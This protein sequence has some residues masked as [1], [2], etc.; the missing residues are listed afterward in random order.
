MPTYVK[1]IGW[2]IFALALIDFIRFAAS[3]VKMRRVERMYG[4]ILQLT[5]NAFTLAIID[6][7]Y[8]VGWLVAVWEYAA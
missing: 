5:D 7:V 8:I 6:V 2:S 4:L 3:V 1:I